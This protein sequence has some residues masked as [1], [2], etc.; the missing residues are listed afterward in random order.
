MRKEGP[1]FDDRG[2][3]YTKVSPSSSQSSGTWSSRQQTRY[4]PVRLET[5]H[6]FA[7]QQR[8]QV[9]W[10]LAFVSYD[11]RLSAARRAGCA[12]S[13]AIVHPSAPEQPA[14]SPELP[15]IPLRWCFQVRCYRATVAGRRR[16]SRGD[17]EV[18][19]GLEGLE[20][21]RGFSWRSRR[22]RQRDRT[23]FR[24]WRRWMIWCKMCYGR[25]TVLHFG[26]PLGT[27]LGRRR[28]VRFGF[29]LLRIRGSDGKEAREP[30]ARLLL[31]QHG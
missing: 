19:W 18:W 15:E 4:H 17:V 2:K 30:V 3:R 6:H 28:R 8:C 22:V 26:Q 13:W 23:R 25:E 9:V 20:G 7:V 27:R 14:L 21:R 11:P 10:H 1:L 16:A 29:A 5:T 24:R 31:A 12:R